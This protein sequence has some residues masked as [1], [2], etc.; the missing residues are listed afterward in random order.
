MKKINILVTGVGA[1]IGYGIIKYLRK[2]K[3]DCNIIGIDIYSDAV[4][5]AWCDTFIQAIPA[6]SEHY[7]DFLVSLITKHSIDL[8]FFGTEQE[9]DKVSNSNDMLKSSKN[10]LQKVFMDLYSDDRALLY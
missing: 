1:I 10:E 7:I 6:I 4:G 2:R 8:V 5:Q 9:L 3:Q